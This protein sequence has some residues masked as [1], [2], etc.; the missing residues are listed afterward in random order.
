MPFELPQLP[1]AYDALEPYLD[2][3]TMKL[4]HGKHH[5]GYTTKFN[6]AIA[7]TDWESKGATEIIGALNSLPSEI[8]GAVRNNGG[9]YIN[10]ALFWEVMGPNQGGSPSG[11]LG[12]AIETT[13]GSFENFKSSFAQ[14]ALT[15]FGSG[16]AW[17]VVKSDGSL[18]VCN[19]PNQDS[20]YTNGDTPILGLD[21]W[22]HAYYKK[23][24]P[25][26]GDYVNEWWNVVNWGKVAENFANAKS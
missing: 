11:D 13:F 3:E 4:H 12:S 14:A 2:E 20:P 25:G 18:A 22:E 21:V 23:Y 10:H 9:G 15:C 26:R 17:L 6:N 8:Q 24:G 1:Y 19:T 5:N 16:W 7:G